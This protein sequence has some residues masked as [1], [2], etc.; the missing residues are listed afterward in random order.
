MIMP[1]AIETVGVKGM[2]PIDEKTE[3]R[4]LAMP[5]ESRA[6]ALVLLLTCQLPHHLDVWHNERHPKHRSRV[7][8]NLSGTHFFRKS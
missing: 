6:L 7:Q 2:R 4:R 5:W 1:K 8:Q 3:C